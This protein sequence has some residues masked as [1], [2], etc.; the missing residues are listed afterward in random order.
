[1]TNKY[2]LGLI[3][4]LWLFISFHR[5]MIHI[6]AQCHEE[7]LEH[8][9]RSY[10]KVSNISSLGCTFPVPDFIAFRSTLYQSAECQDL[11]SIFYFFPS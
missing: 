9:L 2:N 8:Y 11:K 4:K 1:M 7:G 3:S 6:V 10:V 5:V